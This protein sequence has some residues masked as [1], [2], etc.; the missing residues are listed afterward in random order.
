[1]QAPP[2]QPAAP[3]R[4]HAT[5]DFEDRVIEALELDATIPATRLLAAHIGRHATISRAE[6]EVIVDKMSIVAGFI[7]SDIASPIQRWA[8]RQAPDAIALLDRAGR[9]NEPEE[10]YITGAELVASRTVRRE[11]LPMAAALRAEASSPHPASRIDFLL[12]ALLEYD[13][14]WTGLSARPTAAELAAIKAEC[15]AAARAHRIDDDRAEERVPIHS[16]DPA[17][18]D[19]LGRVPFAQVLAARFVEV[20]QAEKA[21]PG[22]GRAFMVHLHGPWGS[23][24]SS[25]LAFLR[26]ALRKQPTPWTVIDFNA[27][28]HQSHRPAWWSVVTEFRRQASEQTN[29]AIRLKLFAIWW[30]WRLRA[31]LLPILI[32]TA[33]IAL[34]MF[35]LLSGRI[36]TEDSIKLVGTAIAAGGALYAL[37]RTILFG[38]SRAAKAYDELDANPYAPVI[39]LFSRLVRAIGGPVVVSIDDLDRCDSAS[40]TDLLEGIQTLLRD[41]P[42]IYVVAGDRKWICASFEKRYCDFSSHVG[43]MGRPLGYLF[44]DK[45]FQISTSVP[46]LSASVRSRFWNGLLGDDAGALPTPSLEPEVRQRIASLNGQEELQKEIDRAPAGSTEQNALRAAAAM[47]IGSIAARKASEH[48]FRVFADLLERNPRAMKRLVNALAMNQALAFLEGRE[49]VP[50]ALARWTILELRWPILAD[51]LIERSSDLEAI[52]APTNGVI[53]QLLADREVAAVMGQ[54]GNAGLLDAATLRALHT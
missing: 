49:V 19:R 7:M 43:D 3:L 40:V 12:L 42:V 10:F 11:I 35:G 16:D 24:K 34:A 18:A 4:R 26:D 37:S 20:R 30:L 25:V 9:S 52:E 5:D 27:W 46:R 47:Q 32:S 54:P 36:G 6:R 28:Q 1:M 23:G 31:D 33:F 53:A 29:S 38:S 48:R 17:I 8:R 21:R 15:R 14:I 2:V 50:E 45:V 22:P 41:A 13:D 51:W 39:T 44:L